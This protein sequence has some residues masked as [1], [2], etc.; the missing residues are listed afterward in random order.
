MIPLLI[1]LV[2]PTK[3]QAQFQ[4]TNINGAITITAGFDKWY[5]GVVNIPSEVDGRPVVGIGPRAFQEFIL[6]GVNIPQSVTNIGSGAFNACIYLTNVFIPNG[7]ISIGD[8]AFSSCG[9]TNVHLSKNVMSLGNCVFYNCFQL[10]AITVDSLNPR[11]ASF[12]GVLYGKNPQTLI[13]SP[14]AK[15]NVTI[16]QGTTRIEPYAFSLLHVD[17]SSITNVVIPYGLLSIGSNAF[18][19]CLGLTNISLPD[20]IREIGNDAF[21]SCGYLTNIHIPTNVTALGTTVFAA[22]GFTNVIIPASVTNI[23]PSAFFACEQMTQ[24]HFRGNAPTTFSP[25]GIYGMYVGPHT[26]FYYLPGALGWQPT[27]GYYPTALWLPRLSTAG[28]NPGTEFGLT[29]DWASGRSV[30]VEACDDL[31]QPWMPIGTNTFIDDV[32]YF[33]DPHAVDHP[34]R[35]YRLRAP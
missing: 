17:G 4:Y 16:P 10:E 2:L 9:L 22:C 32:S 6:R 5:Q 15:T 19:S 23:D 26:V 1:L 12:D 24:I 13:T 34:N 20:S 11:Y 8:H 33:N 30:V 7:V 3:V 29:L 25:Y 14:K 28:I 27:F 35:L 31:S 18:T 21:N